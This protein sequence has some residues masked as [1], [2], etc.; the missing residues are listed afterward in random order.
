MEATG[1]IPWLFLFEGGPT[2]YGVYYM[3]FVW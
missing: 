1:E 3:I 2:F